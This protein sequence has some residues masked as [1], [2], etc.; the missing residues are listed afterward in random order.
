MQIKKITLPLSDDQIKELK[1]GDIVS[2][3]GVVYTARDAAHK[4]ICESIEKGVTLPVSIKNLAVYY[5]GPAPA[6]ENEII[7]SCGPTTSSRMDDYTPALL[8]KGLTVMIGK[9]KRSAAVI[10]SMK[11]NIAVYFAAIG[12]AGALIQSR[13]TFCSAAAYNDLGC[14]AIYEI[15]FKDLELLTAIDCFG[16]TCLK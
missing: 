12:G 1:A 6:K 5:C 8:E 7:G 4:R 9:G 14:E 16:N 2:L 13:V 10:E 11:K 15:H 3:S